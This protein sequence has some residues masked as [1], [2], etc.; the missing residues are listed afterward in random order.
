[1]TSNSR[2]PKGRER[3][4]KDESLILKSRTIKTQ[5][6]TSNSRS[7]RKIKVK[8]IHNPKEIINGGSMKSQIGIL[9]NKNKNTNIANTKKAI[10]VISKHNPRNIV[11]MI[12]ID[13]YT[14]VKENKKKKKG[15]E[16]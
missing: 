16:K 2:R 13:S 11:S 1:M 7:L 6:L 14:S 4:E 8:S 3:E 9:K 5:T 12:N 10:K 15:D